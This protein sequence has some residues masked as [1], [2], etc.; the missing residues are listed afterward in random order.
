MP[1][2]K[3]RL[4]HFTRHVSNDEVMASLS[5]IPKKKNFKSEIVLLYDVKLTSLT[6]VLLLCQVRHGQPAIDPTEC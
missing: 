5:V 4:V 1:I 2:E 3:G 6:F